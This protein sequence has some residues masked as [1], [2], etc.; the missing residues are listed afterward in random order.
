M[1]QTP[2]QPTKKSSTNYVFKRRT[3]FV[4]KKQ[5]R[6]FIAKDQN[7]WRDKNV[8]YHVLDKAVCVGTTLWPLSY[9]VTRFKWYD[10]KPT[11]VAYYVLFLTMEERDNYQ[12][13]TG[14]Y[15]DL[16][17]SKKLDPIQVEIERFD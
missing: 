6:Y 14:E 16:N 9:E 15:A 11:K 1:P 13:H 10:T 4:N 8:P 17:W 7:Y 3:L 5:N 12:I 2:T